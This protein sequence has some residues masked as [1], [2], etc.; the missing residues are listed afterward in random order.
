MMQL[1]TE[2]I[3]VLN[4]PNG[5]DTQEETLKHQLGTNSHYFNH[6]LTSDTTSDQRLPARLGFGPDGQNHA[7]YT[8][9]AH[10]TT[11]V[12]RIWQAYDA[13]HKHAAPATNAGRS[14][15]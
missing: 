6:S 2:M 14:R 4:V 5:V 9:L 7:R 13:A 3:V 1:G 10:R 15:A 12:K 8:P 11:S